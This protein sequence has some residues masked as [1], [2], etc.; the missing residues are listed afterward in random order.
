MSSNGIRHGKKKC[1]KNSSSPKGCGPG[2]V[3][4]MIQSE[5]ESQP[6]TRICAIDP[7]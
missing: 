1:A 2:F 4:F 7:K 5:N 6:E 3:K